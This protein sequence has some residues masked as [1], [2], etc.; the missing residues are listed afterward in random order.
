VN[1]IDPDGRKW[2]DAAVGY[3]IGFTTNIVPGTGSIRDQYTPSDA[4]FKKSGNQLQ[5]DIEKGKAPKSINRYDIGK[6]KH[7]KPH[8]HFKDGN[9][10]NQDG[11][12]KH[13]GR[14]L[15]NKEKKFLEKY[16]WKT[17]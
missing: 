4:S 14:K 5:K 2:Y 9:A 17:E 6:G 15:T 10:L 1:Y 8:V 12:W 16:D 11:T 7:E 3:A 13:G